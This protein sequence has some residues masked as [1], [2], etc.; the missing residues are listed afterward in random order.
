MPDPA[1][2]RFGK[3]EIQAELGRGGFGR[4]FRAFDPTVG[5]LVAIKILTS[6]AGTDLLTRFRNEATAAGNLRHENIVTIYELGEEKGV[7]FIAMEYLEGEDLAQAITAGKMLTLLE[8]ISIMTQ[9]AAG[10]DCAHRNGV[11]HRDVKPANIRLLPDGRVKIMDFGIARL[12]REDGGARLTRQGHVIG[13]LLYMAP[14]QVMGSDTDSLCDV[15]AYGVTCYELLTGRH[16]FRAE[17]PRSI[18]YKITSEDPELIHQLVPECPETLDRV[19]RR[20]LQKDRELRYQTL[21]DLRLDI[22]PVLM[23]LRRERAGALVD[24][25]QRLVSERDLERAC[26]V[27]NEAIDFDATNRAARQLRDSVQMELRRQLLRPRIEALVTKASQS[28]GEGNYADA[29]QMLDAALRLD[30]EN[31]SLQAHAKEVQQQREQSRESWRLLTEARAD[32]AQANLDIALQKASNAA[33]LNPKNI[34]ACTLVEIVQLEIAKREKRRQLNEKLAQTRELLARDFLDEALAVIEGLETEERNAPE[35]RELS[36]RL[37]ER[38]A[39]KENEERLR[40]GLSAARELVDDGRFLDALPRLERLRTEFGTEREVEVLLEEVQRQLAA[41]E[42]EQAVSKALENA[43]LL[44]ADDQPGEAVTVL[45]AALG[46]YEEEPVRVALARARELLAAERRAELLAQLECEVRAHLAALKFEQAFQAIATVPG[47]LSSELVVTNLQQEV[48]A[49]KERWERDEEIRRVTDQASALAGRGDL[50]GTVE[51]LRAAIVR[52]AGEKVLEDALEDAEQSLQRLERERAEAE[53]ER[54]QREEARRAAKQKAA[55][56]CAGLIAAGNLAEAGRA[57]HNA[58]REFAAEPEFAALQ[59]T[60]KLEWE[61]KRRSEATRRAADNARALLE[62]GQPGRA[63]EL[64]EAAAAQYPGDSF[65]E[66]ALS[67]ARRAHGEQRRAQM[68]ESVCRET[69]AC[70]DK[71]DFERALQTVEVNLTSLGG[72]PTLIAMRET[73][74]AERGDFDRETREQCAEPVF[75][76][77]RR[78]PT[79]RKLTI[80]A[81]ACVLLFAGV[82]AGIRLLR[83]GLPGTSLTIET[84]PAGAAIRVGERSCSTPD[85]KLDVGAGTYRVE[86]RLAGY[87]PSARDVS[88]GKNESARVRLFLLPLPTSLVITSNFA[89]GSVYLDGKQA[90]QLTDGQYSLKDVRPGQHSIRITS[91]DGEASLN[92]KAAPAQLPEL[93]GKVATHNASALV[94]TNMGRSVRISC[95]GCAGTTLVDGKQ[96]DSSGIDSGE[97]ELSV[98]GANGEGALRAF[99]RTGEAPG[100][101]I[102]VNSTGSPQG[103]LLLETNIDGASVLIDRRKLSRETQGGRLVV[104]LEPRDYTIEVRKQ[105]YRV[106]PEHLVAKVRKGDSVHAV[107]RLEPTPATIVLAGVS[108]GATVLIDDTPAGTVRGGGFSSTLS[109]GAH[110]VGLRKQG[111]KPV[112]MQT[113]LKPGDTVRVG[114][115]ALHLEA[116][117]PKPKEP[118]Q[119]VPLSPTPR[120]TPEETEAT[121]WAAARSSKDRTIIQTFLAKYPKTVKRQ[122]ALE[123]LAQLDWN[124]LDRNDRSELQ[125]FA[126]QYSGTALAQQATLEI[127]RKEK[128]MAT[129]TAKKDE[130]ITSDLSEISKVLAGYA[131]AFERKDL[132]SLKVLWPGL[133]EAALAQAF[134]GK[135]TIRSQLRPLAPAELTGDSAMVRCMRITE[136]NTQFG[137]Q[138]P[139]EE[140]RTVHLRKE[141]GRW[142]ISAI[143]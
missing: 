117:P 6:E 124:A 21:R 45:E 16:P 7:P 89:N 15:F 116:L 32:L 75:E 18:F 23:E 36:E 66:S 132:N 103:T 70:L 44:I 42:R 81:A 104:P 39:E 74:I 34:D 92:F 99:F 140:P 141:A 8:K 71:K 51:L 80:A 30:P 125:R 122:E 93:N 83:Q 106:T 123:L 62:Q 28:S 119:Q 88:I 135:G 49:A 4:V 97:H 57:L 29:L 100:I 54:L 131:T 3:Y 46:K 27:L 121:E 102:H 56:E 91:P 95:F 19:I 128:E 68:V 78:P 41:W 108:E 63:V 101:A 127:S 82:V 76:V 37:T 105:G 50:A 111:F 25:A 138:K 31:V 139:V 113:S 118:I 73:V 133:P 129:T 55:Q 24:E 79:A 61:R 120:T 136:Q 110:T 2:K 134:R 107:F 20:A 26:A 14:E 142:V 85:C 11:V 65:I 96:P 47:E 90:G 13:T 1:F 126:A 12:I 67:D 94:A 109:P 59:E 77:A 52:F 143:N 43:E 86:A 5:R 10:L 40:S 33:A 98:R 114:N 115:T 112:S 64:L 87:A 53:R 58:M 9:T 38:R 22:E 130:Q 69:R 137:R 72:D 17:D 35:A 60:L 48:G 84:A